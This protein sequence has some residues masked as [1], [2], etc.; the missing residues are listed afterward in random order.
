MWN[1]LPHALRS[2]HP[3]FGLACLSMTKM[4]L[5]MDLTHIKLQLLM[6]GLTGVL[7]LL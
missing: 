4:D 1:K 2:S 7:L 5:L 3:F 6:G